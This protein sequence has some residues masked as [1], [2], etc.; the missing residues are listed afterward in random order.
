M[1]DTLHE[2]S[3]LSQELRSSSITLLRAD[4]LLECLIRVIQS[5]KE[6]PSEKYSEPFELSGE[7]LVF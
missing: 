6:S 1:Y 3:V 2:L 7:T 4:H 5:F